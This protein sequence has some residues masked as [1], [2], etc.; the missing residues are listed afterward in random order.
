MEQTNTLFKVPNNEEGQLF[1]A[2]A[3]KYINGD[4]Y[5]LKQRGRTPNHK[6]LK[7]DKMN[8]HRYQSIPLK[9]AD[10]LGIYLLAKEKI[11]GKISTTTLGI[12]T[13]KRCDYYR[14]AYY[15]IVNS[16]SNID[17]INMDVMPFLH[18]AVTQLAHL[19]GYKGT[20][21]G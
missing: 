2:L 21:E 9:Y 7:K 10:N 17:R 1:L 11:N 16:V 8:R 6:K 12:E 15:K 4:S 3:R 5:V 18:T 14:E 19:T 20:K 13:L